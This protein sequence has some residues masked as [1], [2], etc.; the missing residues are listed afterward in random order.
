MTTI[1][2]NLK[3]KLV[4][5]LLAILG[6]G[7]VGPTYYQE[8]CVPWYKMCEP[9]IRYKGSFDAGESTVNFEIGDKNCHNSVYKFSVETP[10]GVAFIRGDNNEANVYISEHERVVVDI[11]TG[12][13]YDIIKGRIG[14]DKQFNCFNT[15]E[16]VVC[17]SFNNLPEEGPKVAGL[18]CK[19]VGEYLPKAK[20]SQL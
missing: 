15:S 1:K 10:A 20:E 5:G 11:K 3:N 14:S 16:G 6:T 4:T 8:E 18:V 9:T 19:I 17:N 12:A 13:F 2:L 7:C